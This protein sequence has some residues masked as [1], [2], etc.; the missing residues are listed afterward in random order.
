LL[1]Y[2]KELGIKQINKADCPY[3]TAKNKGRVEDSNKNW[4]DKDSRSGDGGKIEM[5]QIV[6]LTLY[7]FDKLLLSST[8]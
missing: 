4:S 3:G 5:S 2:E 1:R 7:Y 6:Q 8:L